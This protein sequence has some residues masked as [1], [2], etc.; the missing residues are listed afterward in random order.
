[1]LSL[2][3][4]FFFFFLRVKLGSQNWRRD[5]INHQI[6]KQTMCVRVCVYIYASIAKFSSTET[7]RLLYSLFDSLR[8]PALTRPSNFKV[9]AELNDHYQSI[10]LALTNQAFKQNLVPLSLALTQIK[11]NQ[12]SLLIIIHIGLGLLSFS[13]FPSPS[14]QQ[15]FS[16]AGFASSDHNI[17]LGGVS[18]VEPTGIL[19]LTNDTSRLIGHAFYPNPLQ[20]INS[21]V[22]S[23]FSFSTAF[24]FAIVPEYPKLGG[25]GFCF[26]ISPT[27]DLPG[28]LPSQYLGLLNASDIG[29]LTNHLLAVEF[30][31]V[32]DFEFGDINDNHVGVDINSLVSNS[33]AI[34]SYYDNG[35]NGVQSVNVNLKSGNKIQAWVDYDGAN[36]V[37][38]V[39]ISPFS[40]KPQTPLISYK[41]DLS[42]IIEETMYVGFSASTGLLASSHYLMGWNFKMNGVV[43]SLDLSTLPSLPKPNKKKT[44]LILATAFSTFVLFVVISGIAGYLFYKIKNADV[45][46]SWE[47][48]C[49]PHRFCY[50]DLKKATKGFRDRELLGFGGFGKVY[51]GVLPRLGGEIAVKRVTNES[52]QGL[53]EFVAEIASIGRLRHR[54]LV[55]LLVRLDTMTC[56]ISIA[57]FVRNLI[58][59]FELKY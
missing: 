46:E 21:T 47:T 48:E 52:K 8:F 11:P 30:D 9:Q 50:S 54:N 31:T 23:V 32:Q 55:Q 41:V 10:F 20:F 7:L 16:F 29:N 57:S 28:A 51:R 59:Q 53:R 26:V 58:R 45:I 35:A 33:S 34:A 4:E 43:Q 2:E 15:E 22:G 25:H 40:T 6:T 1:M 36:N 27:R 13:L 39:T 5:L 37:L 14:S 56:I 3:A 24:A 38:N 12:M 49:G 42:P 18:H 19:Q 44:T 17:S